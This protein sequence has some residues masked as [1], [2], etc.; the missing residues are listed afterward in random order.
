VIIG[1]KSQFAI[2]SVIT[3]AYERL[4][5]RAL[6]YFVIHIENICFGVVSPDATMLACSF[7][8]VANR[9]IDRGTHTAPFSEESSAKKIADSICSSIYSDEQKLERFFG[10]SRPKFIETVNSNKL[11]WAPDGDEAF[12]DGSHILQFDID[13][14]VRLIG[15][16]RGGSDPEE[17]H[18][19]TDI[20][21]DADG[22]YTILQRWHDAF[23]SEWA[24]MTKTTA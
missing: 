3:E 7:D 8:E 9:I 11:I 17:Y 1:N 20:W 23:E 12:D 22:F 15:F 19:L 14:R 24:T 18:S 5:F 16:K 13:N 4:S 10:V 21:L 6:G 2:E